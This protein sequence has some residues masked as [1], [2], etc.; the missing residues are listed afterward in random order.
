MKTDTRQA[1]KLGFKSD[2]PSTEWQLQL[3]NQMGVWALLIAELTV[4]Q[5]EVC[6]GM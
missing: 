5:L 4:T 6:E 3:Y 2:M 1:E